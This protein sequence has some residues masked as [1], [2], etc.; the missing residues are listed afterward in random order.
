MCERNAPKLLVAAVTLAIGATAS[1]AG[2]A[3]DFYS[4]KTITFV[5][6]SDAGGGYDTYTRLLARHMPKYIPGKPTAVVQDEPGGG[7]LR[8]A[9]DIYSVAKKDGTRI[10]LVR[11]GNMLDATLHIRGGQIDPSKYQWIGSMSSD[12]DVCSF[13]NTSGVRSFADLKKKQV[14]VGASGTGS[15]GYDFPSAIN[16]TLHTRMKIITGYKGIADRILAMRQGEL[17]GACGINGSTIT[18]H[19]PHLLS[20]GKLVPVVQ[21]GLHRYPALADVPLTQS[22]ATTDL[23]RRILTTIFSQM[24]IAR[25]FAA[26]PGTPKDRV[27]ILRKAFM[28]AMSDPALIKE[29]KKMKLNIKAMSGKDV[30]SV[31]AAMSDLSPGLKAKVRAAVG[32]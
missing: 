25:A 18:S 17:Q 6:S 22:F 15:Q 10:G 11:A 7:G 24:A 16:Y 3:A 28:Q 8:G 31:V 30:A 21:S 23:Q 2:H 5:V 20:T 12:T 1:G 29:A 32:G 9:L 19:Y 26:P 27:E 14:L 13:W 4:G